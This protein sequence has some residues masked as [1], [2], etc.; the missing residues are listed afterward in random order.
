M[1]QDQMGNTIRFFKQQH[2]EWLTRAEKSSNPGHICYAC[3]QADMWEG[4]AV[5]AITK[6]GTNA[7]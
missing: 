2:V 3:Q 1:V 7:V 5:K 6:F 4:L